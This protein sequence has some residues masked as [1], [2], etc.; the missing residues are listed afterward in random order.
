MYYKDFKWKLERL[1]G[2]N[3]LLWI[4]PL[5]NKFNLNYL[6][7]LYPKVTTGDNL[8]DYYLYTKDKDYFF[9][10]KFEIND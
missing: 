3:I 5:P 10:K 8:L 2:K 7:L 9:Y 4:L 6:E 1:L